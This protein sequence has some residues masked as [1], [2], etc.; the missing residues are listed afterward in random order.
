MLVPV[1]DVCEVC[2]CMYVCTNVCMVP[3][4]QV[5]MILE[6]VYDCRY[7]SSAACMYYPLLAS[8]VMCMVPQL[9]VCISNMI[10][11]MVTLLQLMS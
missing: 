7:G 6:L 11:K 3:H 4:L 1:H 9:H 8:M 10:P 2:L 5:C